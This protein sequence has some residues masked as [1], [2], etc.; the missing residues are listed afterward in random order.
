MNLINMG[1][2][3][4]TLIFGWYM[5]RFVVKNG[6]KKMARVMMRSLN[7][8]VSFTIQTYAML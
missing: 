7:V 8:L 2:L 3:N 5:A 6:H 1:F 4:R